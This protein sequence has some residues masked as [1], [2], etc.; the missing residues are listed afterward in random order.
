M[1][2][3]AHLFVADIERPEVAAEDEHHL[4]RVLRVRPGEAV[5]V[6]DGAGGWRSCRLGAGLVLEPV[7][8][9]EHRERPL[10]EITIGL[11]PI[12]SDRPEWAVQKLTEVGVDHVVFVAAARAVVQWDGPRLDRQLERLRR[13]AR[14]AAMQSRRVFLPSVDGVVAVGDLGAGTALAHPG[15]QPPSL[16][17]PVVLVGPE[18][19]WDPAEVE[20]AGSLVDLGPNT[21]RAETAAVAAGVLLCALRGD[22]VSERR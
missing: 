20:A 9:A 18:G 7:E 11:A 12:K 10:P 6:S 2:T 5:T 16:A 1:A 13:V 8:A 22:S 21:L 19:G 14:E 17:R 15:G 4:A 3:A